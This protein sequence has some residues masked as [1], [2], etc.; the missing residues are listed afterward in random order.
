MQKKLLNINE[1]ELLKYEWII[2]INYYMAYM[3]Y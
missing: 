2:Y 1:Y 3:D